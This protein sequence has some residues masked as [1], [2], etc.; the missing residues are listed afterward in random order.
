MT[1]S[2]HNNESF[3]TL[4][5]VLNNAQKGFYIYTATPGMQCFVTNHYNAPDIAVYDYNRTFEPSA[6]SFPVLA[7]W[8]MRQNARAFFV[9]NMQEALLQD[10]DIMNLNLSRDLL[11]NIGGIWILGMTPEADNRL[12]KIAYDLYSFVR[13]KV[14]FEDE[15]KG[16]EDKRFAPDP[17]LTLTDETFDEAEEQILRYA[18]LREELLALP[19]DAEPNRLLSAAITLDNIAKLYQNYRHYDYALK[20]YERI[21]LIREKIL[22]KEHPDTSDTYNCIAEIYDRQG[23]HSMAAEWRRKAKKE[24]GISPIHI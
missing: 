11:S 7:N 23:S 4:Q 21:M 3:F 2:T 8:A 9:I 14:H 18:D 16:S 20:L 12:F 19:M 6:Y 22:G 10:E 17:T 24:Q 1:L 5:W 15:V 13:L